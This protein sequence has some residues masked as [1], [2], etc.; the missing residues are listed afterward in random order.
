MPKYHKYRVKEGHTH[1]AQKQY[2]GGDVV[3][4]TVEE[5]TGF[6]DKLELVEG[7]VSVARAGGDPRQGE[8]VVATPSAQEGKTTDLRAAILAA[9]DEELLTIPGIGEKSLEALRDWAE[10][11]EAARKSDIDTLISAPIAEI[12]GKEDTEPPAQNPPGQTAATSLKDVEKELEAETGH[13]FTRTGT[14]LPTLA[15]TDKPA[16]TTGTPAVTSA[17][18]ASGAT[19]A[20]ANKG[21]SKP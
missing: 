4:L 1:G 3:E 10:G 18:Q 16:E 9:S 19:D 11:K 20:T 5:A 14:Q 8:L 15:E 2:K 7:K 6:L 17:P 13:D 12:R 21:R